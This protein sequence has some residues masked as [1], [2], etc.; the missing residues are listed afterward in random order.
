MGTIRLRIL[1]WLGILKENA[2]SINTQQE[3]YNVIPEHEQ[4]SPQIEEMGPPVPDYLP[5]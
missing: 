5:V 4:I 1:K 2:S 3:I